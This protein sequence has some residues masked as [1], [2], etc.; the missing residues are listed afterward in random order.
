MGEGRPGRQRGR[1]GL[2]GTGRGG[3]SKATLGSKAPRS[4]WMKGGGFEGGHPLDLAKA[5]PEVG[6]GV[7]PG[8]SR[9][10]RKPPGGEEGGSSLHLSFCPS[11]WGKQSCD[12]E[13]ISSYLEES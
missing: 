1:R 8:G 2:R 12:L 3:E 6:L 10:H 7:K 11:E 9:L 4:R 5:D 13:K